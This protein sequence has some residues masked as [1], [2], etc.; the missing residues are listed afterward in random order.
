MFLLLVL[1]QEEL[2]ILVIL[3][4][5]KNVEDL[6]DKEI[7]GEYNKLKKQSNKLQRRLQGMVEKPEGPHGS[8]NALNDTQDEGESEKGSNSSSLG[9]KLRMHIPARDSLIK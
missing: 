6:T 9:K 2:Q 5:Y 1:R 3:G 7:L 8:N 4:V